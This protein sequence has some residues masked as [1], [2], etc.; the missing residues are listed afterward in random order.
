MAD[1]QPQHAE[2][3]SRAGAMQAA[4]RIIRWHQIGDVAQRE[5]LSRHGVENGSRVDAAVAATNDHHGRSLALDQGVEPFL[6]LP[7]GTGA[8]TAIAVEERM[9][10][11]QGCSAKPRRRR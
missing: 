4:R 6:L 9:E 3:D 1:F 11:G 2:F 5:H 8:E 7:I 10:F